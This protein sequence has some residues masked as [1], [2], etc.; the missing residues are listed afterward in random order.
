[1][2]RP[3]LL[4]MN[5]AVIPY[6][7]AR[8]HVLST[9]MK[10]AAS[11]YE[12]MR[13]YWSDAEQ[14]LYVF[15][16]GE[17]IQRL[18]RSAKIA[19]IP[20]PADRARLESEV[21]EV[22]RANDLREDLHVRLIVF[23]DTDDGGLPSREPVSYVVAPMPTARYFSGGLHVAVSSWHRT[24][25]NAIPPRVKAAAN[26]QNSRLA[27]LQAKT[28][29]YDDAILLNANGMVAEGPGYTLFAVRDDQPITPPV[30]SNI[31]EGVTRAT[32]IT[33][34]RE[35]MGVEVCE[36]DLART[37]LYLADEAF[38]AG[39]AA[40]VTPILSVDRHPV[41]DGMVGPL[42]A[43][44]QDAYFRTVRDGS[45]SHPEWRRAVYA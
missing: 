13:A 35:S 24:A 34:F 18:Q 16:L 3:R 20:L 37:E 27:L 33:L 28:D 39:T 40:E 44:V 30:T 1:M 43:K 7:E 11:V 41:G 17:H 19:R 14:Q 25:D 6:G 23:V 22:I 12:A 26:Y 4:I 36:R 10:Y 5:G 21:L 2:N 9:A 42:T 45:A 31:L 32:L 15:R 38:F 29:G 8:V